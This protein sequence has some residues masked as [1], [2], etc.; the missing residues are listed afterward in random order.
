MQMTNVNTH[1]GE[2]RGARTALL[3]LLAVSLLVAVLPTANAS[4]QAGGFPDVSP[5]NTHAPA[6]EQLAAEGILLGYVDGTFRPLGSITRAQLASVL[7]RAEGDLDPVPARF[8]DVSSGNVHAGAIGALAE[9]GVIRGYADGTFRPNQAISRE[10]IALMISRWLGAK[11]SDGDVFA[12]VTRYGGEIAALYEIG[13]VNGTVAG[14]FEPRRDLSRQQAASLVSRALDVLEN[15]ASLKMLAIN[16]YHGRL[17]PPSG[18]DFGGAAYLKTHLDTIRDQHRATLTVDGGDLVGAT[19]VLSNLFLDEPAVRSANLFGLDVQTVGNHEFDRGR[20][21][22]ERRAEGGCFEDECFDDDWP[23]EGQDFLTLSTNVVDTTTDETL[24][25]PYGIADIAGLSVGFLGVTTV[26]TPNVVSPTGIQNLEFL[27]EDEAVNDWLPVLLEDEEVDVVVVL[28]H[29]GGRQD[30]DKNDC[31]NFTGAAANIIPRFDDGVDVVVS[32][33]THRAYVCDFEDGPLATQ[34]FE[35]GKMFTE[36]DLRVDLRTG[37]V[38]D[39]SAENFDVTRDVDA[40]PDMLELIDYY[41]EL[42]GPALQEVVGTSEVEIPRTGRDAESAQGNLA[43]DALLDQYANEEIDFAFQNSG[44][45]R[46][47]LTVAD[48]TDDGLFNI[49]RSYVLAVWPFGNITALA[50]VNGE[51][52]RAILDN[53]VREVGG[54]RFIQVG[55]LRIEYEIVGTSGGFPSGEV[56]N[57]EYWGHRTE[58]DGTPVD[59]GADQTYRIAMNDFM[60][61]GGDGYPDISEEVFSLQNP[62]EIDVENYLLENSPVSPQ[63]EGRIVDV[64][65]D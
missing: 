30:G 33:H 57:V 9:L 7:F 21:E 37:E 46:A 53:G 6:I 26:N 38:I 3:M 52:L 64:T 65:E 56:V 10:H 29:E 11:P 32:G 15:G 35:Y 49:R 59:L 20:D 8:S 23:F 58:E 5:G 19:P 17:E 13:V 16:D 54:G 42:A 44:G 22:V 43:A 36:I 55:G 34:A 28:M 24:M 50:E 4:A 31:D 2:V 45:L 62:L 39:R 25:P 63:V 12:D 18:S 14:D 40:D 1:R 61:V 27:P 51:T 47:D 48:D 60:T 41:T